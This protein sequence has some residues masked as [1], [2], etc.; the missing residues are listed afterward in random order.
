[1]SIRIV[2]VREVTKPIA[3]ARFIEVVR[4]IEE[5]WLTIVRLPRNGAS[6]E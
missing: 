6:S 2:D 4:S 3:L 5:F 1:M